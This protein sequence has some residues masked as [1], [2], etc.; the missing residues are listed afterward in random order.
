MYSRL[1]GYILAVIAIY[2]LIHYLLSRQYE[3]FIDDNRS[4][5]IDDEG[6]FVDSRPPECSE[7]ATKCRGETGVPH[8]LE[9]NWSAKGFWKFKCSAPLIQELYT[10]PFDRI[11]FD[12]EKLLKRV[13]APK[14]CVAC[15]SKRPAK[16]V[17]KSRRKNPTIFL[18]EETNI[19]LYNNTAETSLRFWHHNDDAEAPSRTLD[20]PNETF[21]SDIKLIVDNNP[22][23]QKRIKDLP[24]G[25][26][27]YG[28]NSGGGFTG[29]GKILVYKS[30]W[31]PD[32]I[33]EIKKDAANYKIAV[34]GDRGRGD[35]DSEVTIV[36]D[37]DPED[38]WTII[39]T[40][41]TTEQPS[42]SEVTINI[43]AGKIVQFNT[44]RSQGSEQLSSEN[45]VI[46]ILKDGEVVAAPWQ[47]S[48]EEFD[49]SESIALFKADFFPGDFTIKYEPD[50]EKN[51]TWSKIKINIQQQDQDTVTN[52]EEC[53]E[54][55][56][57]SMPECLDACESQ[58]NTVA[59]EEASSHKCAADP[60]FDAS[61]DPAH[62]HR[63]SVKEFGIAG[64]ACGQCS[65]VENEGDC[66][67]AYEV[68]G[69]ID[70]EPHKRPCKWWDRSHHDTIRE[71]VQ[72]RPPDVDP[73]D[74]FDF[75]ANK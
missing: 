28:H 52:F 14:G 36:G 12:A 60:R 65:K 23:T 72:A 11:D 54:A 37:T 58:Y 69:K 17:G 13:G 22:D 21:F 18:D 5:P 8:P 10:I 55:C 25:E 46:T 57:N 64:E 68:C 33:V 62:E 31:K 40:E 67:K 75:C 1:I 26:Y 27:I 71:C 49:C 39:A 50:E 2:L 47:P 63:S 48:S 9:A 32:V 59:E 66:G 6:R 35:G 41:L 19:L 24:P 74:R 51:F 34:T 7:W 38:Y 70:G 16:G 43:P 15:P 20:D 73:I 3:S 4:C 29:D 56:P 44:F 53:K 45:A 42:P 61:R 30:T